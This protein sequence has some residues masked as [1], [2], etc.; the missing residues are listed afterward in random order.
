[1]LGRILNRGS[2]TVKTETADELLAEIEELSD[3]NREQ[4]EL[5]LDRRIL[6]LRQRAGAALAREADGRAELVEPDYDRLPPDADLPEVSGNDLTPGL[7]RAALLS[8]GGL[9]VRALVDP[10]DA[11]RLAGELDRAVAARDAV[12]D[13]RAPAEEGYYEE[14]QPLPTQGP[15]GVRVTAGGGVLAMDAPRVNFEL[16]ELLEQANMRELVSEYLGERPALSSHKTTLRKAMPQVGGGWHQDGKFM[17][18]VNTLNLWVSLSHCGDTAPGLDLVPRRL[19]HIV[20]TGT[21]ATDLVAIQV[22]REKAEELA[23]EAGIQRPIFEPGDAVFFD[24]LYLHA[25]AAEPEMPNPRFALEC[26]FFGPSAFPEGY[27]PLAY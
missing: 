24:H 2:S 18:D 16:V 9:L 13:G 12:A 26:W 23:G 14:L 27:L 4:P 7:I 3:R 25:T 5:D 8:H 11:A 15:M 1:L 19:D 10:A 20:D 21:D 22:P 6:H 17:G